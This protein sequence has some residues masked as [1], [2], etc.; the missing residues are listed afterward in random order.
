MASD[1][2]AVAALP[3]RSDADVVR[4]RHRVRELATTIGMDLVT[5]T[6]LITAASELGR[7]TWVHGGGGTL[8]A[9]I[10]RH[11]S[12]VT[13]RLGVRLRF[14]DTGP[15]IADMSLALTSGWT[16]GNGLGLG[17]PGAQRLVHEFDIDSVVGAGT[18]VTTVTWCRE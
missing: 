13:E 2:A 14:V 18:T 17:L 6:K 16:S 11:P 1:D 7:N 12:A 5:Q 10:V 3:L 15:G 8:E 9:S 4:A